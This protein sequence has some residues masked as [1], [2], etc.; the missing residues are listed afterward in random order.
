MRPIVVTVIAIGLIVVILRRIL[1]SKMALGQASIRGVGATLNKLTTATI[2]CLAIAE[3]TA[4][5]GLVFYLMTGDYQYSW[6][7]GG[8]GILLTLYSF[9]R[10]GEWERAVIASARAQSDSSAAMDVG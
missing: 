5:L 7:L 3:L 4:I 6:R 8:V 2:V 10:R 9:P 1:M